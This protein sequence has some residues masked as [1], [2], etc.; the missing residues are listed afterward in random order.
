VTKVRCEDEIFN[1][2]SELCTSPGYI[3]AIS[4]L[5]FKDNIVRFEDEPTVEEMAGLYSHERLI[6]TEIS[7]LL[8]LMIKKEIDFL[9]PKP[10]ILQTYIERTDSLLKEI[11]V[12]INAP[13]N[14]LFMDVIKNKK[15]DNPFTQGVFLREPIFYSGESAYD[16][17]YL[18]LFVQKY[19]NDNEWFKKNKG[20]EIENVQ[21]VINAIM[22]VQQQKIYKFGENLLKT[23][24][25]E[26]TTLNIFNFSI[27]EIKE[28]TMLSQELIINIL[29]VFTVNSKNEQF[30]SL[31][32]YNAIN[33][34]QLI[35]QKDNTY[36]LFQHYGLLEA[37]YESPFYW[38]LEDPTYKKIAEK[39]RGEF[40]EDFSF[41]TLLKVFGN[42]NV[43]KNIDIYDNKTKV[44]EIDVLVVFAN[45]AIVLQAKSKKLRLESRKGN[46]NLLIEDF[47]KAIQDS[48]EQGNECSKFI[49]NKKYKL[50][51][52]SKKEIFVR[53]D[54]KEIYIFCVIS[55]HYPS[56]AFQTQQF[57]K[58][59]ETSIIKPPF[60]MDIF[61]LEVMAEMLSNPLY[62][63]SYT[64]KRT[65]YFK[66]F[67][68]QSELSILSYHLKRN[69]Y[70]SN[71]YSIMMI[72]DNVSS[73]LDL[74][75]LVRKKG[76]P[77]K[78]TP[79]GILTKFRGTIVGDFL[80]NIKNFE[81]D[82][83]IEIGFFLLTLS[84]EAI[85]KIN[86]GIEK[87]IDLY[88]KDNKNHDFT[89][90][91]DEAS[92]GL[93]I[94]T[95]NL[96][97]SEAYEKLLEH[98]KTRKYLQKANNWFGLCFNPLTK[99]FRLG[100]MSNSKWVYSKE[101]G[102]KIVRNLTTNNKRIGRNEKCPCG[103]DKKYK[104]CCLR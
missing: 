61:L 85:Q 16:F 87:T 60:V 27:D 33:S 65:T 14:E 92:T 41:Q 36:I 20:F 103:S 66:K 84:E 3:H 19:K 62:F 28:K 30:L 34:N 101:I 59:E 82:N 2:L 93:T 80:D 5:C 58:Y 11:H 73:D 42:E 51:D 49:Q 63:L 37:V 71:E 9:I 95:N 53:N 46:D 31:G 70:L 57:L 56:L 47:K 79:E 26:W 32:D 29:K 12:A 72:D 23:T 88:L 75:L 97:Y 91:F 39:N 94:H 38:F 68:A 90:G 35:Q 67:I 64:N 77:G 40:T 6:R 52:F 13:A 78:D 69:L 18:E 8:G 86:Q 17:Q 7:T 96:E 99:K 43:Y 76:M 1:E 24:P 15:E 100:L 25:L 89:I 54:F 55:D 4:F 48:Y 104:Q 22:D 44:G 81:D 98:C 102:E 50:V 74:A 21:T 10:D 83:T 45:R